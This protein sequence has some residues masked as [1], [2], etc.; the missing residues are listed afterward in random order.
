MR[1]GTL[2]NLLEADLDSDDSA[3]YPVIPIPM[4]NGD[5]VFIA[6]GLE[7]VADDHPLALLDDALAVA[8]YLDVGVAIPNIVAAFVR[9]F[10]Y[11]PDMG[12]R[13]R[14]TNTEVVEIN[15]NGDD[16]GGLV[17]INDVS[18]RPKRG[19]PPPGAPLVDLLDIESGG[20]SDDDDDNWRQS[21]KR[22]QP[23]SDVLLLSS[24]DEE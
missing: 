16:D 24:S 1:S 23:E 14:Q 17:V 13:D 10:A 20:E 15:D 6:L 4:G 9:R 12:I 8:N 19:R 22:A 11:D 2:R 7:P 21:S 3:D 5:S 18:Q